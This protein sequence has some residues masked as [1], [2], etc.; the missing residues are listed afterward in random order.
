VRRVL[1]HMNQLGIKETPCGAAARR[2][3]LGQSDYSAGEEVVGNAGQPAGWTADEIANWLSLGI[4]KYVEALPYAPGGRALNNVPRLKM[5]D[6]IP[7]SEEPDRAAPAGPRRAP[8][9]A[10]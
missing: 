7:R 8:I 1:R 2:F 6:N 3:V 10:G 9:G 4:G 5:S